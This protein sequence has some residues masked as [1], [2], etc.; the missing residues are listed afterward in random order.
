MGLL[1]EM[2]ATMDGMKFSEAVDYAA[3]MHAAVRMTEEY[4]KGVEALLHNET[5]EW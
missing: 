5:I 4:K 2:L 1:K 3:N